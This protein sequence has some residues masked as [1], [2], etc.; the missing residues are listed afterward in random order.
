M[1]RIFHL[2]PQVHTALPYWEK[3]RWDC[4]IHTV[5]NLKTSGRDICYELVFG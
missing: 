4:F 2:N 5:F 1:K 3:F